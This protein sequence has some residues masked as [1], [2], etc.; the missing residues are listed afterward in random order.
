MLVA[1]G[2]SLLRLALEQVSRSQR[3]L[4]S[5]VAQSRNKERPDVISGA[6]VVRTGYDMLKCPRQTRLV[7]PLLAPPWRGAGPRQMKRRWAAGKPWELSE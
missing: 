1:I 4:G 6:S 5:E 2:S 7:R 3:L